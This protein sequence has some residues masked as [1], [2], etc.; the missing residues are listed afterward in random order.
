M[1]SQRFLAGNHDGTSPGWRPSPSRDRVGS[2][3]RSYV[4]GGNLDSPG[5]TSGPH[6]LDPSRGHDVLEESMF[7]D[8]DYRTVLGSKRRREELDSDP[9]APTTLYPLPTQPPKPQSWGSLAFSTLGGVVGKVWDFCVGGTFRGF[10]AGQGQGYNIQPPD[11]AD[12]P[13]PGMTI[14]PGSWHEGQAEAPPDCQTP[15]AHPSEALPYDP[16]TS[17][18]RASTPTRPAAKRRQTDKADELG[19]NWVVI[20]QANGGKTG[21]AV[22]PRPVPNRTPSSPKNRNSGPTKTTGRRIST[23][24]GRRSSTQLTQSS[25]ARRISRAPSRVA[26]RVET[27][28]RV[29]PSASYASP[30]SPASLGGYADAQPYKPGT[31]R[32][33]PPAMAETRPTDDFHL[34]QSLPRGPPSRSSHRRSHS[35]ASAAS[36]R[37]AGAPRPS[38]HLQQRRQTLAV[39]SPTAADNRNPSPRLDEEA[40]RLAAK[41]KM[42]ER[43][44][45]VRIAAFNRRLQDMIRQ[46]KEALGTTV[47]VEMEGDEGEAWLDDE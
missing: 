3:A 38:P 10:H 30:R 37:N 1:A 14:I 8:S 28:T 19:R 39:T 42:E 5:A 12:E 27:P 40:R 33:L 22:E 13:Y 18:S 16:S 35:N 23:P 32:S 36:G 2:I 9:V 43:D 34:E 44:A 29:G 6:G 17:L 46:G 7:S 26:T 47:D 41:R 45:D 15:L 24:S 20:S 31:P 25:S 4:L 21:D 11:N